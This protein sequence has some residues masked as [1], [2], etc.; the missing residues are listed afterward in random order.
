[1]TKKTIP[2]IIHENTIVL[3]QA[4]DKVLARHN[5]TREKVETLAKTQIFY[6]E[7]NENDKGIIRAGYEN[8]TLRVAYNPALED[9]I[10]S[11]DKEK[12]DQ[13]AWLVWHDTGHL[14]TKHETADDWSL[15][16][17][18]KF[19]RRYYLGTKNAMYATQIA[20]CAGL[21]HFAD[22]PLATN[23]LIAGVTG[24]A[25]RYQMLRPTRREERACDRL[26]TEM[27]G[28]DADFVPDVRD[29][30]VSNTPRRKVERW[31]H[32][33]L[34]FLYQFYDPKHPT[35]QRRQKNTREFLDN[36]APT[37]STQNIVFVGQVPTPPIDIN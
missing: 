4:D 17:L 36:L 2:E 29:K 22:L 21:A 7:W 1:M 28:L 32:K 37:G 3:S 9:M 13:A 24:L 34:P 31:F 25:M 15:S 23:I 35:D 8:F 11:P 14:A 10:N 26:A 20:T 27:T 5:L 30:M 18:G 12:A 33:N 19:L 16:G 6:D